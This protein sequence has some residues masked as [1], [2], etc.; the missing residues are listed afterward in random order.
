[1][2]ND[3][4]TCSQVLGK[5]YVYVFSFLVWFWICYQIEKPKK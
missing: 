3:I 4:W 5:M 2:L 1:M